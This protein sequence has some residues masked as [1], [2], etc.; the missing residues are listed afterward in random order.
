MLFP[1]D[2]FFVILTNAPFGIAIKRKIQSTHL[3][4][5]AFASFP[6]DRRHCKYN[7][8]RASHLYKR[9]CPSVGLSVRWSVGPLVRRSVGPSV[10]WSV[11]LWD[12][13]VKNDAFSL[14]KSVQDNRDSFVRRH[15]RTSEWA[16]AAEQVSGRV[17][18]SERASEWVAY[19]SPRI[20][21]HGKFS[22]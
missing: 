17:L 10:R 8:Q 11:T 13:S 5:L 7:Q 4:Q 9:V 16:S 18:R 14:A 2:A 3:A 19:F 21:S 12:K 20:A 22:R 15:L 1:M 6:A